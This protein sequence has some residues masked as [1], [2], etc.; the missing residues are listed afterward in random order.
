M[1]NRKF[2]ELRAEL[3][4]RPNH[5]E[6]AAKVRAEH[7]AEE[8]AYEHSLKELRRARQLTQVQL[9]NAL[10]TTQ[11]A[12]SEMERRSDLYLSTLRS[13]IEA[14]GGRLLLAAEFDEGI[15]PITTFH[16]LE[17]LHPESGAA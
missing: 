14:M 6:L 1:D 13:Y 10:G 15:V 11:P 4:A 12:V 9:A 8:H 7:E 17:P 16:E 2:S 5:A 3:E